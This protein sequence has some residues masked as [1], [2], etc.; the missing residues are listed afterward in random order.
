[1]PKRRLSVL[2]VL[3]ALFFFSSSFSYAG[4]DIPE[5]AWRRPIGAPL[6]NAGGKKPGLPI[7]DDGYWQGAPVGG[8]GA[9][10][11]SRTYRGN[12]E[13]WHVKAGIH[14]YQNVP[15]NQFAV[16]AQADGDAAVAQVLST[17]KPEHGELS[18]WNWT[19]PVGAGDYA[20]LYPKSWFA[21]KSPQL[22]ITLT[23][24]QFSPVIPD[25][26][27][28]SS[29]PV[30]VYNW[31]VTNPSQKRVTVSILFSW[32][33]M[34]GWF[35]D[36]TTGFGAALNSQDINHYKSEAI[37]SSQMQGIVF[38]RLRSEPVSDEWDGQF[39]IASLAGSGV[40]ISYLTTYR[41]SGDGSDVWTPFAKDG[42]LPNVA[43][44]LASSGD[45]LAGAIAV[46][47]TLAPGEKRTIPMALAWDLPFIQFGSGRKWARHYT[48]FFD[49]FGTN[50]W[51]L[52]RTAL[53]QGN[54]WSRQIDAWQKPYISDESKPLWYRG[55]L[56]NELYDLVD[57]GT[58]WAHEVGTPGNPHHPSAVKDDSFSY[59]ECF[60]YAYYGTLDVRFY[61]SFPLAKFWPE[62]EKQEM[63]EYA[64]TIPENIDQKYIWAWKSDNEHKL[65]PTQ[66]K[67]AGS[68]PHDLGSPLEDALI[69]PNQ[70]N[71]QSVSFWKDLNSKYVLM[72][73]RDY[74]MSGSKDKAFL[75]YNYNAVKQSMQFLRQFDKNNDGLIENDGYPDQTYDNW[76]ARG[77]SAYSG[78]LYLAALRATEEM[79]K[80][81][82]DQR[83][84]ADTAALF[85]RAQ[86]SFVKKL[87]NGTYFN[88]DVGSSYKDAIMAEQLAGQWYASLTGL[89]D[90][91]PRD[92]QHSALKKV[93]DFNVMKLQ[94]GTMG[95]L[96]GISASGEVLKDNEQ[97][98]EVWTGV[99]FAVAATMLQNGLREEGFNTAKG[100]YNVVYDQK[101]YWFRTPEAYDTNGMY[102]AS[103]YMRPGAIWSMEMVPAAK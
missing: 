48:R 79:A 90:L 70:Y 57:G 27:K 7:I 98:E 6:Q 96:N 55:M 66:R 56:F 31:Y 25:N 40:E 46:R 59:L 28:E 77:E 58:M 35:R 29:Y 68:A 15:A 3:T 92:M 43:A 89:G 73:W 1:M 9:G 21:Y 26:Y 52:A 23:L 75:Q 49:R 80:L 39:A 97:T 88:Y 38:D 72:V 69:L 24:E 37:K 94:N 64:D 53:E 85:K 10:T 2:F 102:R 22:P 62:I 101:G 61:G 82:G 99:T 19:Y 13:R 87:W 54:D 41:P 63:R 86:D 95:A 51:K 20:A 5:A 30:A 76:S 71:Y 84:A 74:V 67:V 8:F 47:F 50:A 4:D 34:V 16:F 33:N 14:K 93:Y 44:G 12:F 100:V 83:T 17:Q 91:V 18:S 65:E 32:T 11:F 81:L 36:T 42:R 60:D 45:S 78:S 103:M